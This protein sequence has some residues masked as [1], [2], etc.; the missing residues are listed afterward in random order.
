M[1]R[2]KAA[3]TQ[4]VVTMRS[5]LCMRVLLICVVGAFAVVITVLVFIDA[6]GLWS[7]SYPCSDTCWTFVTFLLTLQVILIVSE[8]DH[9]ISPTEYLTSPTL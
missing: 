5:C 3:M 1:V 6:D 7:L 9:L 8:A 2:K 4:P